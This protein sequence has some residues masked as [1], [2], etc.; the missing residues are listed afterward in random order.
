MEK[1][2]ENDFQ[3]RERSDLVSSLAHPG[4]N[5]RIE[6]QRRTRTI[7]KEAIE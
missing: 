7:S 6:E 1:A 2:I 5:I 3:S 4:S